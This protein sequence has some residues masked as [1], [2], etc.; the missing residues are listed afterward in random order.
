LQPYEPDQV[1]ADGLELPLFPEQFSDHLNC[2][3]Q[4]QQYEGGI[5]SRPPFPGAESRPRVVKGRVG[6]G[7]KSGLLALCHR[8]EF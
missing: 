3:Q 8:I 1:T 7:R 5:H 6:A 2:G 4:R